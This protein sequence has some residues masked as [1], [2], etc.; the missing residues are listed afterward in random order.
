MTTLMRRRHRHFLSCRAFSTSTSVET[1]SGPPGPDVMIYDRLAEAVKQKLRRL[2][3]P[4]DRFLKYNNPHPKHTDHIPL[5][6]FPLTRVTTLPNGLRV[7]SESTPTCGTA[8][9]GVWID[10]GSRYESEKTHGMAH[11]LERMIFKG[12]KRRP[13]CKLEED[14]ENIGGSLSAHTSREHISYSAKVMDKDVPQAIDILADVLQNSKFRTR[15]IDQEVYA[16][17]KEMELP[18]YK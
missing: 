15:R 9:V 8:T 13:K 11:F 1:L 5:L 3:N 14:V 16:F 6:S 4:D 17:L 12:T 18:V 7:A 10:A 2:D